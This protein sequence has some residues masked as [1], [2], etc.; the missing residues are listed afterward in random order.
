MYLV[1]RRATVGYLVAVPPLQALDVSSKSNNLAGLVW[2]NTS[3]KSF[4]G[5]ILLFC[6]DSLALA[7][8]GLSVNQLSRGIPA[9][10]RNCSREHLLRSKTPS[11]VSCPSV[12]IRAGSKG[13]AGSATAGAQGAGGPRPYR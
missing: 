13:R 7:V 5:V 3:N 1:I 11:T 9:R 4:E 8:P 10:F 2:L 6:V 12:T